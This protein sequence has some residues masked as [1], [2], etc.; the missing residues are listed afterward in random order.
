M[1]QA[2][3]HLFVAF[4]FSGGL[5]AAPFNVTNTN[6][7]GAGSLRQ[8][9]LDANAN[10][11][12]DEITFSIP[13]NGPHTIA[14][15]PDDLPAITG[16]VVIDGYTQG[17]STPGTVADD[18]VENTNATGALNTVLKIQLDG[19]SQRGGLFVNSSGSVIRG[20]AIGGFVSGAAFGAGINVSNSDIA[21]EG[22]FIGTDPTGTMARPNHFGVTISV[23]NGIRVGGTRPQDR[24]LISG[25]IHSGVEIAAANSRQISN[26]EVSGNLIGTNVAG[27]GALGNF[28]G[29]SVWDIALSGGPPSSITSIHIG[30]PAAGGG[31]V[32]S[33]NRG[34]GVL[35]Q[36]PSFISVKG[37]NIRNNRIGTNA[38]GTA[39]LVNGTGQNGA[40]GITFC[41]CKKVPGLA[42]QPSAKAT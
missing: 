14:P 38:A 7:S 2:I 40:S 35:V 29:V 15:A 21:I 11:G 20:L 36:D 3:F 39:A 23:G 32:I 16:Q 42:A 26:T 4:S 24:N 30:V 19:Q 27:T 41:W 13:G 5:S 18:A 10:P 28:V 17:D 37:V 12:P 22:C 6:D 31:N 9:I 1:K 25:N 8:A 34:D 33:G